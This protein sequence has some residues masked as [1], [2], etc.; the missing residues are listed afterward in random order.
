MKEK[1]Y[2]GQER[3]NIINKERARVRFKFTSIRPAPHELALLID[4]IAGA[5]GRVAYKARGYF[6]GEDRSWYVWLVEEFVRSFHKNSVIYYFL[7]KIGAGGYEVS[8]SC[9]LV[10]YIGMKVG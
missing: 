9:C 3:F 5:S 10:L 4:A 2:A 1:H 8:I 7:L 6:R